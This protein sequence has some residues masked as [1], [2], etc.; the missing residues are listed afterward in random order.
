[1]WQFFFKYPKVP[2]T[3]LLWTVILS[4]LANSHHQKNHC[5]EGLEI[6][7]AIYFLFFALIKMWNLNRQ[8]F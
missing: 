3:M 2:W 7:V 4:K 6:Y 8:I 1:M 5:L